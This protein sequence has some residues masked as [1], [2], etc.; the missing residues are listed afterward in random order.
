[1]FSKFD[2]WQ[3]RPDANCWDYVRQWLNE[4]HG[5]PE[6]HVPKYGICPNDKISMHAAHLNV[7]PN[8]KVTQPINGSIAAQYM[9]KT[10]YHVGV[11]DGDYVRHTGSK[12]GTRKDKLK[13]FEKMASKVVYYT[14]KSLLNGHC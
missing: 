8:F 9:G 13:V 14:H 3:Y 12:T 2:T 10:L 6:K 4:V 5:I 1:M 11:V 7:I